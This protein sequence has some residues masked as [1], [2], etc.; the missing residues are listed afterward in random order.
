MRAAQICRCG[1]AA[2]AAPLH[3]HQRAQPGEMGGVLLL[4]DERE[5]VVESFGSLHQLSATGALS[6][7]CTFQDLS[8]ARF[9]LYRW[10]QVLC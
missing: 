5:N 1:E 4:V 3:H 6:R 10:R 7:W 2:D 9:R 8:E